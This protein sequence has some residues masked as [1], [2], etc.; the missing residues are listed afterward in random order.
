MTGTD[1]SKSAPATMRV[2][3]FEPSTPRRRSAKSFSRLR[4]K[5]KVRATKSRKISAESAAKTAM[6]WL[7]PGLRKFRSKAVCEIR[8][9]SSKKTEID[10]RITTCLRYVFAGRFGSVSA[11]VDQHI[12][13]FTHGVSAHAPHY[14]CTSIGTRRH[15]RAYTL[16]GQVPMMAIGCEAGRLRSAGTPRRTLISVGRNG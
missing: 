9:A 14:R 16:T 11:T 3:N 10:S 15:L 7:F 1:E 6:S 13:G 12:R 8:I 2:R 4:S 5:T